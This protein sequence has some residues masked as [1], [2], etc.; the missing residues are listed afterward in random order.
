MLGECGQGKGAEQGRRGENLGTD[1]A[2][3]PG[4]LRKSSLGDCSLPAGAAALCSTALCLVHSSVRVALT[5]LRA[6]CCPAR[7][8]VGFLGGKEGR[9]TWHGPI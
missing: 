3:E 1:G 2:F 5:Q 9:I 4:F 8:G 6:G 7:S